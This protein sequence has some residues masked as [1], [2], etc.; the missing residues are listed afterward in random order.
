ME[1]A[2]TRKLFLMAI[3]LLRGRLAP[4]SALH[5]RALALVGV[6]PAGREGEGE[7]RIGRSCC[8]RTFALVT[9]RRDEILGSSSVRGG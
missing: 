3:N 7:T 6:M 2:H 5:A 8:Y 4:P 1:L 9:D